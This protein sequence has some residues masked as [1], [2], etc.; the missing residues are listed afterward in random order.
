M[1]ANKFKIVDIKC[2]DSSIQIKLELKIGNLIK[3]KRDIFSKIINYCDKSQFLAKNFTCVNL[4][5]IQLLKE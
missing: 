4:D 2:S 1:K 5:N 3:K